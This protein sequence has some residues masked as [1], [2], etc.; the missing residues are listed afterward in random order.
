MSLCQYKHHWGIKSRQL[1]IHQTFSEAQQQQQDNTLCLPHH[2]CQL[3]DSVDAS[4]TEATS[5]CKCLSDS[6]GRHLTTTTTTT[7]TT[8][9]AETAE[10]TAAAAVPYLYFRLQQL[11]LSDVGHPADRK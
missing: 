1:G 9:A 3:I 11:V 5:N 8:T 7:T 4:S 6:L 2:I 10:S